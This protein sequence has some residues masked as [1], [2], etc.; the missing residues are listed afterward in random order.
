M[1]LSRGRLQAVTDPHL[2]DLL[3][4]T[5]DAVESLQ[6]FV[7][8]A[9]LEREAVSR[10]N[11]LTHGPGKAKAAPSTTRIL[12]PRAGTWTVSGVDGHFNIDIVPAQQ[13]LHASTFQPRTV[14]QFRRQFRRPGLS[15]AANDLS[16]ETRPDRAFPGGFVRPIYHQL[17][18]SVDLNWD[19]N[20][21][22]L[23]Y[24]PDQKTHYVITG[25]P[26]ESRYW[27]FRSKY[28]NSDYNDWTYWI[29]P[30]LCGVVQVYSGLAR[31]AAIAR[32]YSSNTPTAQPLTQNGTSTRINVASTTWKEGSLVITYNSGFV[33]PGSYGT[34]FVYVDDPTRAGGTVTYVADT[35]NPDVTASDG[36]IYF[37]KIVTSSGGG[38]TGSGGGSGPCTVRGTMI[39]MADGSEKP[40]E[41][42]RRGDKLMAIDGGAEELLRVELEPDMPC[43]EV[44]TE[45]GYLVRCSAQ[46]TLQY[47]GGGF[48]HASIFSAGDMVN[49]RHGPS[50]VA[51]KLFLGHATVYKLHLARTHT[52]W[53]GGIGSHNVQ[54]LP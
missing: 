46:H 15:S 14:Q 51:R 44:T 28:A 33:D 24:G 27:R 7:G 21:G 50:R 5:M 10:E 49:T 45:N 20:S 38:G 42:L 1:G 16:F 37:G 8:Y 18:A 29:D 11:P 6:S 23:T 53:A 9:Q 12:P 25:H 17:Q 52:Y 31:T 48:D 40:V 39:T 19:A 3:A 47:A 32:V 35:S 36:R 4:E 54:K 26:N 30:T 2:R 22:V 34:F 13:Y 41:Q 43:F